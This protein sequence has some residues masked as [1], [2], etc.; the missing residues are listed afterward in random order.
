MHLL[1][2]SDSPTAP[3]GFGNVTRFVCA[4][5]AERGHRVSILGWQTRGEPLAWRGCTVYPVRLAGFGADVLLHYLRR[6]Q[7]DVL[8]TLA[9]IWWLTFIADPGIAGFLRTAR[10]PWALY[11]PVDGDMGDGRL[12]PSWLR[13]LQTVDL[14]IA[15]SRYGCEVTAAN[16]V[17]PSY[18]PHGVDTAVFKP[19]D[20]KGAAKAA[21]GYEGAFVILSDARNQPRKMLP[22]TLEIFRRFAAD[23]PDVRLHLHC[24]PQDPAARSPEYHYDLEA[25]VALLGLGDQVRFSAGMRI[26]QGLRLD[27]LA[28][29]YQAA[30]VHLLA[31]WGE[32]FGLPTLQAASAGVVPLAADYTASRELVTG[33]GEPIAVRHALLDQ[34]QLRRAL[35]D[36][37]DAVARLERLYTDRSLLAEKARAARR[38]AEAYDW[39]QVVPRW[40]DLLAREVPALRARMTHLE[41]G[42]RIHLG[43]GQAQ[44][45]TASADLGAAMRSTVRALPE[46]AKVTISVVESTIGALTADVLRDATER[47]HQITI[48][49]ALPSASPA[50]VKAREP[51]LVYLASAQDVEAWRILRRVFPGLRAWSS[52]T[53]DLGLEEV[54]AGRRPTQAPAAPQGGAVYLRQLAASVLA[55]DL[56]GADAALPVHA[57]RLGVPCVG[58]RA[59]ATQLALWPELCLA[60]PDPVAAA[61]LGRRVLT[62]QGDAAQ[63]WEHARRMF[64]A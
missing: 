53:L 50:L 9:D 38:F 18:I 54:G 31:S 3:S 36:V 16:G 62:D 10:I 30:D 34:F 32:G 64:G 39:S 4:G 1:W 17:T 60:R 19:P 22:R 59:S 49:A 42:A 20:D 45:S 26:D 33:H 51:G 14:P 44:P 61:R 13:I 7:P 28:A 56:G 25:D 23:K 27:Q 37:D 8:V 12:P 47:L 40:H 57:V 52:A 15:M 6:L 2:M 41:L 55:F 43:A 5:L 29:I 46:G 24:D 35:I 63:Q 48:P 21:V 58:L 11:Y